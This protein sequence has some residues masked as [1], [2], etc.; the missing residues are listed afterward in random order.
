MSHPRID[1]ELIGAVVVSVGLHVAWLANEARASLLPQEEP[2][3]VSLETVA[4]APVPPATPEPPQPLPEPTKAVEK[5]P[6]RVD[7]N[8]KPPAPQ[9]A[10]AGKTLTAAE[11]DESSDVAD[12]TM[13]QGTGAAYVGG[14][15]THL[16]S[17][18]IAVRGPV[19]SAGPVAP[20]GA[21]GPRR[22]VEPVAAGPDR[23]RKAMPMGVDWNC[24]RLFPSD[25]EAGNNAVVLIAVTVQPDGSA[26]NVAIIRDPGHG[27]G[28]AARACA[29]GQRFNPA[30]DREG[31]PIAATT[32]PITVR[33]T[34]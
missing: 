17:S 7:Q 29:L 14:T 24:S 30:W 27:F 16:G 34:R 4:P 32:P 9:A 2:Q 28:A 8:P 18:N 20:S 19:A 22:P 13:V 31:Q 23:S 11:N 6:V 5:A 21:A 3:E 25:P 33:F 1:K 15:T 10:Q 12:F 26:K